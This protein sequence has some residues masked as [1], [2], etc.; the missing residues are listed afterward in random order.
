MDE[1]SGET[2]GLRAAGGALGINQA[3]RVGK[4]VQV[5]NANALQRGNVRAET[6]PPG[7]SMNNA[8]P[9]NTPWHRGFSYQHAQASPRKE[10]RSSS[11]GGNTSPSQTPTIKLQ[12]EKQILDGPRRFTPCFAP[13]N[14]LSVVL[15]VQTSP[16]PN[17][18]TNFSAGVS[19]F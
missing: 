2:G 19:E 7:S 16:K 11:P 1:F 4:V 8:S 12:P 18:K 6:A 13:T 15:L 17:S 5:R 9:S 10:W 3:G 14:N